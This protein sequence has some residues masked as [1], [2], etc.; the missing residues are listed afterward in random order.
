MVFPIESEDRTLRN[1][2]MLCQDN[3]RLVVEAY[4]KSLI[5]FDHLTKGNPIGSGDP[6]VDIHKVIDDS[7][8]V[9]TSTIKEL[10]E[11]GG[12]LVSRDDFL[13]LSSSFS[14]MIDSIEVITMRLVEIN[15]REWKL[16][17]SQA[18]G[19]GNM[20]DLGFDALVKLRD[21]ITSL[22]F[23][24]D[25]ATSYAKEI[26]EIEKKLDQLNIEV[27]LDIVTSKRDIAYI[28]ILRDV[29]RE[30]ERLGDKVHEASDL[31]RILAL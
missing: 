23:N 19:I 12:I 16:S 25:K 17:K 18:E 3:A 30:L 21:S 20:A 6:L 2:L 7:N 31:V 1:L 4:R 22:G 11:I 24:S 8:Q 28:L 5:L 10:S 26:D 15:A 13:R 29:A 27:D 9:K 14:G